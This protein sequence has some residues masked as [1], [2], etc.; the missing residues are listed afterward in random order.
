MKQFK[1]AREDPKLL[2]MLKILDD[3]LY[4]GMPISYEDE[5]WA[6]RSGIRLR[7]RLPE[8]FSYLR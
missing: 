4:S 8:I 3:V 6:L 2:S 7:V 5:Q 1:N